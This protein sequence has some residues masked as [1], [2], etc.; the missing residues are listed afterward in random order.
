MMSN[1]REISVI[2]TVTFEESK[3]KAG[4]AHDSDQ[5]LGRQFRE[6]DK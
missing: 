5:R 6:F 2:H 4:A 3:T 1:S